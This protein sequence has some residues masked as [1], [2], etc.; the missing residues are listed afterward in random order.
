MLWFKLVNV[1]WVL[2]CSAN[3]ATGQCTV[4]SCAD[5][6]VAGS[7][8]SFEKSLK[9]HDHRL[10]AVNQK[11]GSAFEKLDQKLQT[12]DKMFLSAIDAVNGKLNAILNHVN[13]NFQY[14]GSHDNC[15][16]N[17]TAVCDC[18]TIRTKGYTTSGV[19][20]IYVVD[21]GKRHYATAYCDMSTA[22]RGW[23]IFQR[24]KDGTVDFFR[25]WRDYEHGFGNPNGEYWLG[26]DFLHRLTSKGRYRLRIDME[27]FEGGSFEADYLTFNISSSA[28]KYRLA[29]SGF[30]ENA[31]EDSL[32]FH[33]GCQF[34]TKDSDNDLDTRNCA[35]TYKGAWWY[36]NC[37]RSNLNGLYLRGNYSANA[38]LTGWEGVRWGDFHYK[39]YSLKTTEMKV[40]SS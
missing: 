25:D 5:T 37:H 1:Y 18:S 30:S 31:K 17:D 7:G 36:K 4:S 22:S 3:P 40:S 14:R 15:P 39:W 8:E 38:S 27:D 26:N 32:S 2:F 9:G 29:I 35:E 33:N 12:M 28:D 34:S 19:Y 20:R 21:Q 6:S 16:E 13:E 23:T 24:R 11:M 10:E